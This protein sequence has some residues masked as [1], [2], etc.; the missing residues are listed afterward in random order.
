MA[1]SY[2]RVTDGNGNYIGTALLDHM[3]DADEALEECVDM[4][5]WLTKGDKKRIYEAWLYGWA[6]KGYLMPIPTIPSFLTRVFGRNDDVQEN[7]AHGTRAGDRS[8]DSGAKEGGACG[9]CHAW[10]SW[11]VW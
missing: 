5:L 10:F 7:S 8:A 4:F 2:R 9:F 3:G 11:G 1:G 6:L